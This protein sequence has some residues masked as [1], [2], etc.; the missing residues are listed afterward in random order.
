MA[1]TGYDLADFLLGLPQSSSIRYGD[2]SNYFLQNQYTGY[3][4][5]EWKVRPNFTLTLGVRYE[6]FSPWQQKYRAH[7]ESRYCAR[8]YECGGCHA[9]ASG[10]LYRGV[11]GGLDQSRPRELVAARGVGVETAMD[12]ALYGGAGGLWNLLQRT[13]VHFAGFAIGAAAAVCDVE[14]G[15]YQQGQFVDVRGGFRDPGV[16]FFPVCDLATNNEHVRGGPLLS[17]AVR[18]DLERVDS[19]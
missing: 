14:R 17:D 9:S 7:G 5:D 8:F 6:F 15:E 12:E 1:G 18:G 4:Q 19:A 11:S 16:C 13:G 10:S 3:A 2:S